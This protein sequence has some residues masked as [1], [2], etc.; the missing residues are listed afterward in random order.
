MAERTIADLIRESSPGASA[1]PAPVMDLGRV[2]RNVGKMLD[3][4]APEEEIDAYIVGEGTTIDAVKAFKAQTPDVA[5]DMVKGFGYGANEGIDATLNMIG[6]PIRAPINYISEK[7][8]YGEVIP[9]VNAARQFNVAGPAETRGGKAV[10]AVGEVGGASLLPA[11][12]ILKAGQIAGPAAAGILGQAA[13]APGAAAGLEAVSAGG[14][15]AGVATAR[16][17]DLGPYGELA[18]G[19]IGGFAA[20]N[21]ANI[22]S[23]TYGGAKSGLE[24]MNRQVQRAR[25]PEQAAY[26]DIAD[27]TVKAGIDLDEIAQQATPPRSANLERRGFTQDDLADIITRQ[28]NGESPE[29]VASSYAHLVDEQNRA[30][31]PATARAYMQRY[32]DANPT[33]MNL[34]D[35]A[36]EQV[37][38][39]NAVPL[40]NQ[41]R[42]DMAIADDPIAAQR[43]IERQ[44]AQPG[45][46]ADIIEQSSV[47]GRNFEDEIDRLAT[48]ARQE[49]R[50]AYEAAHANAQPVELRPVINAARRVAFNRKG[51]V[52]EKLNEAVDLF[53][54]PTMREPQQS[55][56]TALRITK[57]QEKLDAASAKGASPDQLAKIKRDLDTAIDQDQFTRTPKDQE[58]G[59]PITELRQFMDARRE[60]DQMIARSQQD[61]RAT[62]LTQVLTDFRQRINAAAR[63]NNPALVDADAR[64]AGNRTTERI[65][66]RGAEMGKK[67]TPQTR[68]ALRDFRGMTP[69][70]QELMR[71]A[72]ERQM[73]DAALNVKRGGAA[74]DQFGTEAFEQIVD[75]VYPRPRSTRGPQRT[76]EQQVYDRGRALLRN[77]RRESISTE[78]TRD[79]LSGSRTAPLA[80]DMAEMME[81]PRAAADAITGRWTRVLE[82]LSNRLTRVIG[83]EAARRRVRILTETTPGEVIPMLRRLRDEARTARERQLMDVAIRELGKVGRR[84]GADLGTVSATRDQEPA[85]AAR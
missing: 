67:L 20:P 69:T 62:P 41:A 14:A 13:R 51:E 38:S 17:N 31:T 85:S 72:F 64:F 76:A 10:Q 42:T 66:G 48:T 79:A 59:T 81:G 11:A 1:G 4:G 24:H 18:L 57:L 34:V 30:F 25:N 36:K 83:Q 2:K 77:L 27:Q 44:R 16:D 60:L 5:T 63:R 58:V 50:A 15:G 52:S 61:G 78:T 21:V 37:G 9:E 55:P 73:A 6:A 35:L 29:D 71:V 12:G 43:L 54:A 75:A 3:Q 56:A 32:Q 47:N 33:P 26:R 68:Q 65:L 40:S 23:R 22:A 80:D 49:E 84:P 7:L 19:L 46:T 82:N 53:F 8:G 74:A 45:R 28:L 70:Q 39:G